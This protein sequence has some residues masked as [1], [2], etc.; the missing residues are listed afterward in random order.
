MKFDEM[1]GQILIA[2]IPIFHETELQQIKIHGVESGGLWVECDEYT[3]IWLEKLDLPAARTPIFFVPYHE[4]RFAVYAH[5]KLALSEK[6]L[7]L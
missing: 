6:K 3:K 1:I 4:I 7:G 5:S 2:S